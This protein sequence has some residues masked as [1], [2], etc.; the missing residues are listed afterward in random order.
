MTRAPVAIRVPRLGSGLLMF[1]D[2]QFLI[3]AGPHVTCLEEH[4]YDKRSS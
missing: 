1:S 4:S 3:Y 2:V